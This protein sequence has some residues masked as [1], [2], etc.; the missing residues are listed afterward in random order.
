MIE[1][2]AV[3]AHGVG[4]R[5]DLP[6]PFG[7]ALT[8]AV[9]ALVVSFIALVVLWPVPRSK[10]GRAGRPLPGWFVRAVDSGWLPGLVRAAGLVAFAWFL[11]AAFL[12][13]D[14]ALNPV[15]GVIYVLL[16]VG[17][18]VFASALLGPVYRWINPVRTLHLLLALAARRD[19][20]EGLVRLPSW[21][22]RWPGVLTLAL[23]LWLEL[24]AADRATLAV[25]QPWILAYIGGNLLM[26]VIYGARW[27]DR[28]DPFEV[29]SSLVARVAPFGR[30]DDG[31]LVRRTTLD[32]LETWP[33]LPG[34]AL[35]VCVLLGGTA[36]D[37]LSNAPFW[38]RW[39]QTSSLSSVGAATLGLV[40]CI[41][42][43]TVLY[44]LAS[45]VSCRLAGMNAK[46]GP[47]LFA[48][49]IVPIVIG[50]AI[51]HYY[52]LFVIVG[53]QTVQ[54]LSDPLGNGSDLLGVGGNGVSYTWAAPTT[55]ATIQVSAVVIGHVVGVIAAHERATRTMPK[56]LVLR[57]QLPMLGVM[58]AFTLSGLLLLFAA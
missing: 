28:G 3:V 25:L 45:T 2:V 9:V 41:A 29:Y 46:Q 30:R 38:I 49:S 52:S 42:V 11:A 15:P 23:F 43:V 5:Q 51:A 6:V 37:G 53:Q 33:T 36:F 56:N 12:G 17:V 1:G 13:L 26:A 27:F 19:A 24:A 8:A 14:D 31:T 34:D 21:V 48:A 18:C 54:Q 47:R 7:F 20:D 50:Y 44:L 58:I 57:S 32:S 22:G 40:G 39:A 4:G 16:W 55:V 35:V 10:A